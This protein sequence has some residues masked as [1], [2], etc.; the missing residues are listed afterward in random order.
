VGRCVAETAAVILTLG[1]DL[2]RRTM[3][4]H[5]YTLATEGISMRNAYGTAAILIILIFF[6]NVVSNMLIDRFVAK[7]R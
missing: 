2:H 5:F 4:V 7:G 1:S 3:A 6:I